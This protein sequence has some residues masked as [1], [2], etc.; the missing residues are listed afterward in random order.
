MSCPVQLLLATTVEQACTGRG[1]DGRL[2]TLAGDEKR[3]MMTGTDDL[4]AAIDR[5]VAAVQLDWSPQ[6]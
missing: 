6:W 4:G 3:A 2:S 1:Y 5:K